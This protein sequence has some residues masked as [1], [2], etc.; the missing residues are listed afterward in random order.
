MRKS[1]AVSVRLLSGYSGNAVLFPS[2]E[3][4]PEKFTEKIPTLPE[5][6][7]YQ[8]GATFQPLCPTC[9]FLFGRCQE[10][11][12]GSLRDN[13]SAYSSCLLHSLSVTIILLR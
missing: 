13:V 1:P 7:P 6:T 4:L 5:N 9:T 2:E 3:E 8:L 10:L 12:P 11:N